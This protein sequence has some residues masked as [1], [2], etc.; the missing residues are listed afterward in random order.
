M[1]SGVSV[2]VCI[3]GVRDDEC[4]WGMMSAWEGWWV[5]VRDDECMWEM[6]SACEGWWV[7]VRDDECMWEMMNACEGWWVHVR[8]DECMW[9]IMSAC[10]R[11]SVREGG[12]ATCV[13]WW[14]Q[15]GKGA[16]N[17]G[18]WSVVGGDVHVMCMCVGWCVS[19]VQYV[20]GGLGYMMM[21]V[22]MCTCTKVLLNVRTFNPQHACPVTYTCNSLVG[23]CL[24]V[25]RHLTF[26]TALHLIYSNIS[27]F[28][29]F[30]SQ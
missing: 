25:T 17:M 18:V 23:L 4:M 16:E 15:G 19:Y 14:M 13:E 21:C 29:C 28:L 22:R 24:H 6:M 20:Q 5:H 12:D 1:T 10:E 27:T 26:S 11:Q 9:G 2:G 30:L 7:Y 3:V 8:D